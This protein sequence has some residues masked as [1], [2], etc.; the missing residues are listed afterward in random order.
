MFLYSRN[1]LLEVYLT[2]RFRF[3]LYVF[4][5]TFFLRIEIECFRYASF[6]IFRFDIVFVL[7]I[8]SICTIGRKYF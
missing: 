4:C 2:A 1:D 7:F 8:F 3:V 5:A 6:S